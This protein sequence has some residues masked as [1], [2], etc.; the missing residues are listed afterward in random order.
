M[1]TCSSSLRVLLS[2]VVRVVCGRGWAGPTS[3]V[4]PERLGGATLD[5]ARVTVS[6]HVEARASTRR[7]HTRTDRTLR[8]APTRER[9]T[10]RC[11][12]WQTLT[13]HDARAT[14]TTRDARPHTAPEECVHPRALHLVSALPHC[15]SA[16]R[17]RP[18]AH[19]QIRCGPSGHPRSSGFVQVTRTARDLRYTERHEFP[20][21]CREQGCGCSGG[22][23][24]G[25]RIVEWRYRR[26]HHARH[27]QRIRHHDRKRQRHR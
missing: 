23:Q 3:S 16:S 15:S 13:R 22:G 14:D 1:L 5:V 11:R 8:P 17:V 24:Q 26:R 10:A 19:A 12:D 27:K 21:E 9:P 18:R 6:L 7:M 4:D 25:W 20:Q 2:V